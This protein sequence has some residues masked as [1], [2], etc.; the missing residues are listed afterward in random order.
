MSTLSGLISAGGGGGISV[1]IGAPVKLLHTAETVTQGE[2]TFLRTGVTSTASTYPN[3]PTKNYI[4]TAT[5]P[6]Q[7]T[8]T[9][10]QLSA[11]R[12][13]SYITPYGATMMVDYNETVWFVDSNILYRFAVVSGAYVQTAS[14]DISSYVTGN[15][16]CVQLVPTNHAHT[17][18]RGKL[19]IFCNNQYKMQYFDATTLAHFQTTTI[20]AS[21]YAPNTSMKTRS[22]CF[23]ASSDNY[24]FFVLVRDSS[25]YMTYRKFDSNTGASSGIILND[26]SNTIRQYTDHGISADW[27]QNPVMP[28]P[29]DSW[30]SGTYFHNDFC[31]KNYGSNSNGAARITK[32]SIS[33]GGYNGHISLPAAHINGTYQSAFFYG[34]APF[35]IKTTSSNYTGGTPIRGHHYTNAVGGTLAN[36]PLPL[37]YNQSSDYAGTQTSADALTRYHGVLAGVNKVFPVTIAT[38]AVG[39]A[40]DISSQAAPFR[41]TADATHLYNLNGTNVHKYAFSNGAFVSTADISAKVSGTN[42]TGVAYDG[43][44]FFYVLDKSNSAVHKYNASWAFQSTITLGG[45]PHSTQT[46]KNLAVVYGRLFVGMDEK[47]RVYALDGTD[48]VLTTTTS[49]SQQDVEAIGSTYVYHITTQNS[50]AAK[51]ATFDVVGVPSGGIGETSTTYYRV[52]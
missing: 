29:G 39:T 9:H 17:A 6:A 15:R 42:A 5:T 25:Y 50:V 7:L 28:K 11:W 33:S 19:A 35:F 30:S 12:G 43:S 41:F 31:L 45:T 40:I 48:L 27:L 3:A 2:E 20:S 49:N 1:P 26:G 47:V 52:N 24:N 21:A 44:A 18:L 23:F 36:Y 32:F 34:G 16:G 51:T 10:Q 22:M 46:L 38:G 14:L 37:A 4:A 8:T 13:D